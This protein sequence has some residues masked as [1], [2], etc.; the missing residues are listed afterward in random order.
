MLCTA[1]D[2]IL[3]HIASGPC[4]AKKIIIY[5]EEFPFIHICCGEIHMETGA[6]MPKNNLH[7]K[8]VGGWWPANGPGVGTGFKFKLL[9]FLEINGKKKKNYVD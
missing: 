1:T 6:Q 3:K 9:Q 5:C 2:L 8:T 4:E 7:L